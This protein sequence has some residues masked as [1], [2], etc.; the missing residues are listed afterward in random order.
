MGASPVPVELPSRQLYRLL[1]K[2]IEYYLSCLMTPVR[3]INI[4]LNGPTNLSFYAFLCCSNYFIRVGFCIYS[5]CDKYQLFI[6][7]NAEI[8]FPQDPNEP[9]PWEKLFLGFRSL[10]HMLNWDISAVFSQPWYTLKS[11]SYFFF[12]LWL[13]N[14]INVCGKVAMSHS[15]KILNFEISGLFDSALVIIYFQ[16]CKCLNA[17]NHCILL[18]FWLGIFILVEQTNL[19]WWKESLLFINLFS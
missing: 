11:V 13:K 10:G 19:I 3:M 12:L 14:V 18:I 17:F 7:S 6:I 16:L 8:I 5:T 15:Q 9:D 2:T 4:V 1:H